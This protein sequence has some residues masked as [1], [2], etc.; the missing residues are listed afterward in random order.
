MTMTIDE[1]FHLTNNLDLPEGL[2]RK[3]GPGYS[4][5]LIDRSG[6]VVRVERFKKP[7]TEEE[8]LATLRL[9]SGCIAIDASPGMDASSAALKHRI[10]TSMFLFDHMKR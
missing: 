10:A 8:Q 5:I 4:L 9:Q 6:D 7:P 2:K 3:F 1:A